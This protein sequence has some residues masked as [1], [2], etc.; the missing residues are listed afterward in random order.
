[1]ATK[2]KKSKKT[3][4]PLDN[5]EGSSSGMIE[6]K[7]KR[8]FT[9][10]E[11]IYPPDNIIQKTKN[12]NDELKKL[13]I[14]KE[15]IDV[16]EEELTV[17]YKNSEIINL[18]RLSVNKFQNRIH[19]REGKLP[20]ICRRNCVEIFRKVI[21]SIKEHNKS[22][23][24]YIFGPS[25]L[26]KSYSIYYLVAQ[27]RLHNNL[28]VTYINGC[29]EWWGSHENVPYEFLLNELI[30]TFSNDELSP[31]TVADWIEFVI[32]GLTERLSN[33]FY[34]LTEDSEWVEEFMMRSG[35]SIEERFKT[36]IEELQTYIR[37]NGYLWIWVFDQHN[38][39]HK[40]D[41]LAKYPF[42]LVE[43]LPT[44]LDKRG[45]IIVS[46]S[47]N[48]EV[49]PK[50]FESWEK[51]SMYSGYTDDEFLEW[52]K[53]RN[54][55]IDRD[56]RLKS[57]LDSIRFWTNSYPLEL[58]LWH[59]TK[60][61]S[62]VEKTS[63]YLDMRGTQIKWNYQTFRKNLD[64]NELIS[65]NSCVVSMM[66]GSSKPGAI[67]GMN[68][69]FMYE[70]SVSKTDEGGDTNAIRKT[71]VAIHPLAQQAIIDCH[72]EHPF[73]ELR[74]MVSAV[75]NQDE[76][77]NDTKGRFAELYIKMLLEYTKTC[78]FKIR[79]PGRNR[80]DLNFKLSQIIK[81][82]GNDIPTESFN[83]EKNA[84]FLPQSDNYPGV[85]FLIWDHYSKI[86]FSFQVTIGSLA[87]HRKSRDDFMTGKDG[88]DSL[89]NK[90][91]TLCNTKGNKVKFIWLAPD[92]I[93]K[94]DKSK[95]S[96]HLL[97]SDI[98]NQFPVLGDL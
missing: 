73:N 25:G 26:G 98:K 10:S 78:E 71:I 91:A 55:K 53:M 49:F 66:L 58:D 95:D 46:A 83:L 16:K 69:Q 21:D 33:K 90:W 35:N 80:T 13:L 52:C 86:L 64:H 41:V 4:T 36:F 3:E 76:Y 40:Y 18:P 8:P 32:Y 43:V 61:S 28:R 42:S 20:F 68:R 93:L 51:F 94:N 63:N 67:Y 22:R 84:L 97:F 92:D 74:D 47:A 96:L 57:Q 29:E 85:D 82:I 9:T 50:A 14:S 54:Y 48:N 65:L 11:L 81:F 37:E 2:T 15:L 12:D 23:G 75:F 31:L 56:P 39:L 24:L 7:L 77:S 59:M 88:K 19:I 6:K 87:N 70:K 72:P 38:A 1:M 60:G 44:F 62:L 89:K 45:L 79:K 27:L 17:N 5:D 30:C 34:K